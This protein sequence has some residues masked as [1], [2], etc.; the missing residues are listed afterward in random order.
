MFSTWTYFWKVEFQKCVRPSGPCPI[1]HAMRHTIIF[2]YFHSF[3]RFILFFLCSLCRCR[4]V[5]DRFVSSFVFIWIG[6]P[7]VLYW[8][9]LFFRIDIHFYTLYCVGRSF[10]FYFLRFIFDRR[11]CSSPLSVSSQTIPLANSLS[12]SLSSFPTP[13]PSYKIKSHKN[14]SSTGTNNN[15][16]PSNQASE[17]AAA[18]VVVVARLYIKI[19]DDIGRNTFRFRVRVYVDPFQG[20]RHRLGPALPPTPFASSY[21][22]AG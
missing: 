8:W 14:K 1:H 5:D 11:H 15:N 17:A 16:H 19:D 22:L 9:C 7:M 20:D 18:V 4:V 3:F 13:F 12:L 2:L 21:F 6:C 10:L